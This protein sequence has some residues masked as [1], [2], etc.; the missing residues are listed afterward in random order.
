MAKK[1]QPTALEQ[2]QAAQKIIDS[3]KE[4]LI[5]RDKLGK[6]FGRFR[7][8]DDKGGA[9]FELSDGHACLLSLETI[10]RLVLFIK[11]HAKQG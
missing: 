7:G 5:F 10:E 9:V 1:R 3:A 6:E 8:K 11:D 4:S 2:I